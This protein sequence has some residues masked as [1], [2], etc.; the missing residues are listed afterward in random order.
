[1]RRYLSY[2]KYLLIHKWWVLVYG[3][4]LKVPLWRLII[5][6]WTKFLPSE[7]IPY[8][9]T[10]RTKEGK[11][12]WKPNEDFYRAMLFHHHRHK[13]HWQYWYLVRERGQ[14]LEMPNVFRREMLADWRAVSRVRGT[15]LANWYLSQG[16]K[17]CLGKYTRTWIEQQLLG[18]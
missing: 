12:Q 6:D 18:E 15:S 1:M 8:A 7:F 2:T 4:Q 13:H 3:W 9:R 17:L 16:N 10:F 5:H 14:T 11:K